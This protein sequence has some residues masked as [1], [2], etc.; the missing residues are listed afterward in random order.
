MNDLPLVWIVDDESAIVDVVSFALETQGFRCRSF[1]AARPVWT[2]LREEIPQLLVLD[3][4][5]PD[6]S[7]MEFCRRIRDST[8]V[9]ILMLTAKGETRDRIAGLEAGADDYVVKPFHPREL[10]L[11]AERLVER[12][13]A[14]LGA[15]VSSGDLRLDPA[16]SAVF[17]GTHQ[18][19]LTPIEYALLHVLV[20][21]QGTLLTF[22]Q[23]I[24]KVWGD[25]E[26]G[27]NRDLLKTAIYRLRKKLEAARPDAGALIHSV[28]GRGYVFTE[29]DS[30]T[31]EHGV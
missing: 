31:G 8:T 12:S 16:Q 27:G 23:L 28:R 26:R 5:L 29:P 15:E 2:A 9:P 4:M 11:R 6:L 13:R 19:V 18:V 14:K 22:G 20:S 30:I 24:A 25:I 1:G 3:V 7:G 10:A 17:V 21:Q